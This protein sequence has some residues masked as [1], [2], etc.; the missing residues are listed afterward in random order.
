MAQAYKC[1]CCGHFYVGSPTNRLMM[2][3]YATDSGGYFKKGAFLNADICPSCVESITRFIKSK[4]VNHKS[5]FEDKEDANV[6][7]GDVK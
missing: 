7:D 3:E 6:F 4:D 1:D 5:V 2:G